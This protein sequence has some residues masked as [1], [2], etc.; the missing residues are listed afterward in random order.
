M[1]DLQLFFPHLAEFA[2][3][4]LFKSNE[5][6][7]APLSRLEQDLHRIIKQL[8]TQDALSQVDG[9]CYEPEQKAI[10]VEKWVRLEKPLHIESAALYIGAGTS[11][12]PTA[13][14]KGPAVIG[15][16]CDIRQSAYIRGNALVGDH[17]VIGH[18]T[19]LKNSIVMNH[20]EAGHFNYIGDSILGSYVN[21]GAGTKLANLQF[22]TPKEKHEGFIRPI[23]I[24]ILGKEVDT[25]IG[26]LGAILGD[27]TEMGCNSVT[28]PGTLMGRNGMVYP[29]TTVPKA[30]HPPETFLGRAR[31]KG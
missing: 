28:C 14:I 13:I 31:M 30:Y 27:Y 4:D 20:T 21:L 29:N 18:T 24:P 25:G 11:L 2:H 17:S 9:V 16:N 6:V 5:P 3:R 8:P 1:N 19:E 10:L 22:R 12:E 15:T 26:K 7:W 23:L